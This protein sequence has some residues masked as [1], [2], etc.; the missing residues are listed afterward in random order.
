MF[1][2]ALLGNSLLMSEIREYVL[3]ALLQIEC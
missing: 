3:A 2:V 1:E